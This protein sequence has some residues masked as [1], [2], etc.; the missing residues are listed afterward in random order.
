MVN[1]ARTV[2][3]I[4]GHLKKFKLNLFN[5]IGE[6]I[7]RY[8]GRVVRADFDALGRLEADEVPIVGCTPELRVHIDRWVEEKRNWVYWD[9]GAWFRIFATWLPRDTSG[10]GGMYRWILNGF[11]MRAIRDVPIDRFLSHA[12]PVKPWRRNGRHIVIASPT[13]TYGRFHRLDHWTE[14]MVRK[15]A[16]VTDR[17]LV[18]REKETKRPLQWDLEGAHCLIS[19]GSNAAVEAVILGCPVVVDPS[20][21]AALVGLTDIADVEHPIYPDRQPW[22]NSMAYSQ[23]LEKEILDGT[24]WKLIT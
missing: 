6:T 13:E 12:P 21:A 7:E 22:L 1:P 3:F 8:G 9:R 24:M 10:E 14:N 4:P 5:R 2:F 15:L 16:L 17:Q 19:H 23:F 20:S 11:Q 18:L